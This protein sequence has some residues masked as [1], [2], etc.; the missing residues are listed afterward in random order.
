MPNIDSTPKAIVREQAKNL[1]V[2]SSVCNKRWWAQVDTT[3]SGTFGQF[4]ETPEEAIANLK[5][6]IIAMAIEWP[7]GLEP[8]SGDK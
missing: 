7:N 8:A 6:K 2:K 5:G 1:I 4:G 3:Y